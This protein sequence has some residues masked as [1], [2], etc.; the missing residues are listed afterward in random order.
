MTG[1]CERTTEC[2][3]CHEQFTST[4]MAENMVQ[5]II[6]GNIKIQLCVQWTATKAVIDDSLGGSAG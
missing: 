6:L 2:E 5:N 1:P 3:M 4:Y